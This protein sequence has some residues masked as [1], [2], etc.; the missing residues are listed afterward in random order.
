MNPS[1]DFVNKPAKAKQKNWPSGMK[2]F[3]F[4]YEI[5]WVNTRH[6]Q[7]KKSNRMNLKDK[8]RP[9]EK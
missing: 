9:A 7:Q 3:T 2:W 4:F 8:S 6:Y 5:G 1:G